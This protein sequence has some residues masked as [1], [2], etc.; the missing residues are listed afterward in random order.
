MAAKGANSFPG[1]HRTG[2]EKPLRVVEA[3]QE[4]NIPFGHVL[5]ER[6][7]IS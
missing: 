1:L 4:V 7:Q 6:R 5:L 3:K 2:S